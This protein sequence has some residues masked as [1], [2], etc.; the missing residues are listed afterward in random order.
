MTPLK[1]PM[2]H[3]SLCLINHRK[4]LHCLQCLNC[5]LST[6]ST[7]EVA[8]NNNSQQKTVSRTQQTMADMENLSRPSVS[9]LFNLSNLER[10][11][12]EIFDKISAANKRM[13]KIESDIASN[14]SLSSFLSLK[15]EY[16]SNMNLF[17][18]RIKYLEEN[19]SSI[20][21]IIQKS[22]FNAEN[23]EKLRDKTKECVTNEA[24]EASMSDFQEVISDKI[25]QISTTKS[26]NHRTKQL[27]ESTKGICSQISAIESMLQCK[28]DKSQ[29]PLIQSCQKHLDVKHY[30]IL[31][32]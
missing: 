8:I 11:F 26:S 17:E 15:N 29:V 13:D 3:A 32:Y 27:E 7:L 20:K 24:F 6:K 5:N 4:S 9:N 22:T 12:S 28:V 21:P 16:E 2:E 19:V 30:I 1:N 14:V 10:V 18:N 31:L 23:I 25:K